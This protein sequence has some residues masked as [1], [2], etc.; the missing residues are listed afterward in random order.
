M[1]HKMK[2]LTLIRH[3]KSSWDD[4][5]VAD[6]D[7]PLNERGKR[8]A[9]GMG[10][11]LAGIHFSPDLIISSTAKRARSTA[12]RIATEIGYP[13]AEIE[14]EQIFYGA[15]A[16]EMLDTVRRL[17]N[18]LSEVVIVSHNPGITDL[19]NILCNT[20]IDNIPTCGVVRLELDV[21]AWDAVAP[22]GANML[23]FDFPK[24]PHTP[25]PSSD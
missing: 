11:R 17:K 19:N 15:T 2:R 14:F 22:G 4:T 12:K 25:K 13:K 3:A 23:D 21:S 16:G 18:E 9:P 7:R 10:R 8:D 24:R 20:H 5:G 6:Y 1:P